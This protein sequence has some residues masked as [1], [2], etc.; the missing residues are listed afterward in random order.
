MHQQPIGLLLVC[1]LASVIALAC[2]PASRPAASSDD[3]HA[4]GPTRAGPNQ[5]AFPP[6]APVEPAGEDGWLGV[7]LRPTRPGDPGVVVKSAVRG[8]PAAL[9]GIGPGDVIVSIDGTAV[10]SPGQVM[11]WARSQTPGRRGRF[12]VLR[13]AE[14]RLLAI[15]LA[16]RPSDDDLWRML[17]VGLPAPPL[18]GLDPVQ[19][20]L[21]SGSRGLRGKVTVLVFWAA[22]CPA[23]R[24]VVPLLNAW[25][26]T[27]SDQGLYVVGV[28]TDP[29]ATAAAA[30]AELEIEYAVLADRSTKTTQAYR[31]YALPTLF[32]VDRRGVVADV[33]VGYSTRRLTQ[34]ESLVSTLIDTPE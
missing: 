6:F 21:R 30:A 23:C 22:W 28:T 16:G 3:G 34:I 31:G 10:S 32:V 8:S 11:E 1:S 25:H 33:M 4:H 27:R 24:F 7:D 26:E 14:L 5:A 18:V 13:Q 15:E 19:G 29:A 20:D 12:G 9:A 17:Y 2:T